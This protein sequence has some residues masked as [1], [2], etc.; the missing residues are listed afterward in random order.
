MFLCELT[1]NDL[2]GF[3]IR[4]VDP[5]YTL[6][7]TIRTEFT[8]IPCVSALWEFVMGDQTLA[9]VVAGIFTGVDTALQT[10]KKGLSTAWDGINVAG[11]FIQSNLLDPILKSI[12]DGM[13]NLIRS[14]LETVSNLWNDLFLVDRFGDTLTISFAGQTIS[15]TLRT[16][17]DL[18]IEVLFN[19]RSIGRFTNPI[20][21]SQLEL[22]VDT[23]SINSYRDHLNF[24]LALMAYYLLLGTLGSIVTESSTLD[25]SGLKASIPVGMM[26]ATFFGMIFIQLKPMSS[27]DEKK[28]FLA[29][30]AL[31]FAVGALAAYVG[32]LFQDFSGGLTYK[33]INDALRRI[34]TLVGTLGLGYFLDWILGNDFSFDFPYALFSLYSSGYILTFTLSAGIMAA[35][36]SATGGLSL[37]GDGLVKLKV[38]YD[39]LA[40]I[41]LMFLISALIISILLALVKA[42]RL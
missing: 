9:D 6:P 35:K 36:A 15:I 24:A 3:R 41:R 27:I 32:K 21:L 28:E 4:T 20:L 29:Y 17:A 8:Y 23:L 1:P 42:G 33:G 37:V 39:V 5:L 10:V 34:G 11:N 16:N 30:H 26:F 7:L 12:S 14:I 18:S 31:Y 22:E 19:N 25:Y 13:L 2:M 38:L 40:N